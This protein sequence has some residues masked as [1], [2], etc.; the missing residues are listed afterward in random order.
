MEKA[1]R[2]MNYGVYTFVQF[3]YWTTVEICI[4]KWPHFVVKR[5]VV[6]SYVANGIHGLVQ[7]AI[8][9]PVCTHF[10]VTREMRGK[11]V[12]EQRYANNKNCYNVGGLK[13]HIYIF[14]EER[15]VLHFYTLD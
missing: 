13:A 10:I 3:P 12:R 7:G 9:V 8:Q 14:E 11:R 1:L 4:H 15:V 6:G 2:H 5:P